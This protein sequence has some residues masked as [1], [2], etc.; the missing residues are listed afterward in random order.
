MGKR[1][2]EY[3]PF[4]A[5][6]G[7]SGRDSPIADLL[8]MGFHRYQKGFTHPTKKAAQEH[9]SML[10]RQEFG[11]MKRKVYRGVRIKKG[12]GGYSVSTA[13]SKGYMRWL[14]TGR[15]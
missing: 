11:I 6:S 9:A 8:Q 1:S 4:A 12:A 10:R 14:R 2:R 5:I 7:V 15:G 3:N 13:E